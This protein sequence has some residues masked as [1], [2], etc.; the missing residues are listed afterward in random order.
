MTFI[1]ISYW[2]LHNLRIHVIITERGST[3]SNLTATKKHVFGGCS[4][5]QKTLSE[6]ETYLYYATKSFSN[7]INGTT[8]KKVCD[9]VPA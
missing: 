2:I 7:E 1:T 8:P 3:S 4:E 5:F 6:N 9:S